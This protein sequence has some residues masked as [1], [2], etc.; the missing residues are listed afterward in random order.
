MKPV[1]AGPQRPSRHGACVTD[2]TRILAFGRRVR[3]L[4]RD[5]DLSQEALAGMASISRVHLSAIERGTKVV[6]L[7]AIFG[8]ADALEISPAEL[9]A[10]FDAN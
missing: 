3:R 7:N 4:R 5:R 8:L 2:Q 9:F 10:P 1:D 6:G